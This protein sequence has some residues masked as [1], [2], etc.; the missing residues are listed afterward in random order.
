MY[1]IY[2]Y[3]HILSS[4]WWL[5]LASWVALRWSKWPCAWKRLCRQG[6]IVQ[7]CRLKRQV[8]KKS[9]STFK[10]ENE[11]G[12]SLHL[13]GHVVF[14]MMYVFFFGGG[15]CLNLVTMGITWLFW[16]KHA[17]HSL[18]TV[19][20]CQA[21]PNLLYCISRRWLCYKDDS[22]QYTSSLKINGHWTW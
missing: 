7:P 17:L 9:V 20:R 4:W 5:M 2:I 21:G 18:S 11:K 22:K 14:E 19:T 10:G 16:W 3:I 15:G 6:F 12:G 13:P 1:N 8:S